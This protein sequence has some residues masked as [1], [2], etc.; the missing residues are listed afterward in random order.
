MTDPTDRV[1]DSELIHRAQVGETEAFDELMKRYN[2]A[3]YRLAY[4]MT[5]NHADAEDI[6][7]DTFIRAYR[8]IKRFD[9][10]FRFYTWLHRICVNLCINLFRRR[11]RVRLTSLPGTEAGAEWADIADPREDA[12]AA[13]L[14]RDLDRAIARLPDDQRAVF[15]LRVKEELS[16]GEISKLLGI[17]MGTVMSR[18][19]RAREK[20]RELL[21]DYLPSRAS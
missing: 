14:R 7:Q 19:N 4:S 12:G 11:G 15:V 9:D 13:E 16:Y 5:R 21:R 2:Q 18:L 6:C 17:P 10:R 1:P 20:L 8:A 3:V